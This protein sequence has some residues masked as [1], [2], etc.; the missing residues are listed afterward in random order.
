M[1]KCVKHNGKIE[2]V[3]DADAERVVRAGGKY[4]SKSEWRKAKA[5]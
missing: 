4:V 5:K 3:T 2:R 1:A